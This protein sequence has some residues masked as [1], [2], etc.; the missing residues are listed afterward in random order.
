M[1]VLVGSALVIVAAHLIAAT[2]LH[3][4]CARREPWL[5]HVTRRSSM[6]A[7]Y[8]VCV[9][10]CSKV[11]RQPV[12]DATAVPQ[13]APVRA[14]WREIRDEAIALVDGGRVAAPE[15]NNDPAIQSFY[16]LGW[17]RFYLRWHGTFLPSALPRCPRTIAVLREIPRLRG[18][19]FAVLPAGARLAPHTD[20]FA[21]TLRYHLGLRT[22]NDPACWIQID[23]ER[24]HWRDGEALVF[25]ET[26]L[27]EVHNGTEHDRLILFCD[28]ERPL[29][30]RWA[31]AVSRAVRSALMSATAI[32][33]DAS[34]PVGRTS[35]VAGALARVFSSTGRNAAPRA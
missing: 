19:M 32:Q 14:A 8:N 28:V 26:Y 2:Y 10:A 12:L 35:R 33:N 3:R 11:G 31:E 29:R 1:D 16:E 27:H 4:R 9:Y 5:R 23:A 21:G 34:D 25:D 7:L 6:L 20:P 30:W 15:W 17:T 24:R 18:A 13:M 22:P